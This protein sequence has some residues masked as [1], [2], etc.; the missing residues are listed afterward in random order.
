MIVGPSFVIMQVG[1]L[2]FL[3]LQGWDAD[4]QQLELGDITAP[5]APF[6]PDMLKTRQRSLFV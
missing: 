1:T 3:E 5:Y 4:S 2:K 6:A